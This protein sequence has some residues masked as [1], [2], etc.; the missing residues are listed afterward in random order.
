MSRSSLRDR[1]SLAG[2]VALVTGG[3]TGIG[4]AIALG[5]ADAGAD[6][7]VTV[8][9]TSADETGAAVRTRGRRYMELETEL[10]KLDAKSALQLLS[11]VENELGGVDVLV[12]NAGT[13]RRAPAL[14][15]G[16]DAWRQ[17]LS[18][19][20]DAVWYLCQAA[21]QR[22]LSGE[23]SSNDDSGRAEKSVFAGSSRGSIVNIAS[24]LSFQGGV[25]V[26][27]YAASKHGVAGLTKALANE[28]AVR[29]VNVNAIAPG[30][31]ITNNTQALRDD[32]KR[33]QEILNRIPAGRWGSPEDLA[34]AAVFLASPAAAYIHGHVLV[35]DG[36][37]M[38]R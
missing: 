12:N 36:G 7:A 2:R 17:V 8:H 22:M 5:M 3:A 38:A 1:F 28:W 14:E 4:Q 15:H 6:I 31:I 25:T 29:G 23:G 37:W 18:V 33:S 16:E 30:Y 26:P 20:L 35:V 34:D 13:I 11:D 19:N 21:G 9:N 10:A 24:L 32:P 27:G